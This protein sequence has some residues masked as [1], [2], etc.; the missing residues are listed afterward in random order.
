MNNNKRNIMKKLEN[1]FDKELLRDA[2]AKWMLDI[3]RSYC[4]SKDILCATSW[5]FNKVS[6]NYWTYIVCDK[7]FKVLAYSKN[8]NKEDESQWDSAIILGLKIPKTLNESIE[9]EAYCAKFYKIIED[10]VEQ[11]CKI[12]QE[13]VDDF[14]KKYANKFKL[15]Q[16]QW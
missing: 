15:S 5:E 16:Y 11:I 3:D 6:Y 4:N 1:K 8:G 7:I 14:N 10:K 12:H 2:L 13:C 9:Y